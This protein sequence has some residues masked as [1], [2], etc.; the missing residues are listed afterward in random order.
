M[1]KGR[2][3]LV[4]AGRYTYL[5]NTQRR[6]IKSPKAHNVCLIDNRQY[7]QVTTQ[8]ETKNPALAVQYP[9]FDNEYCTLIGGAHLGFLKSRNAFIE[10][11]ILYIK[12][13]I[14]VIIDTFKAKH[15]HTYQQYFHFAPTGK[16]IINGNTAEFD[17]GII[18]AN[19][20]FLTP[21][22]KIKKEES[23]YS[24]NYNAV[25]IMIVLK[26]NLQQSITAR[27]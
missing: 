1:I 13:D 14:Y 20:H 11:K 21:K 4:D 6:Y 12:P 9:C 3:V 27:Q 25:S 10:R 5:N 15:L 18:K 26:L 23:I 24:S 22:V 8:W 17:D 19:L 16:A 7:L 2:D